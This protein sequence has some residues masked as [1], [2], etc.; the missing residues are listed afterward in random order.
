MF[1]FHS[2]LFLLLLIIFLL[3]F[4]LFLFFAAL[5][6][7][8]NSYLVKKNMTIIVYHY[9]IQAGRVWET[10]LMEVTKCHYNLCDHLLEVLFIP[11]NLLFFYQL[12]KSI[13]FKVSVLKH[14]IIFILEQFSSSWH[15][16]CDDLIVFISLTLVVQKSKISHIRKRFLWHYLQNRKILKGVC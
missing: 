10:T 6:L 3:L 14:K 13:A 12:S 1:N 11:F 15:I 2:L 9:I 5:K 8:D 7:L 4:F 16:W